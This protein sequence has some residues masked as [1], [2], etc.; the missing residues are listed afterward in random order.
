MTVSNSSCQFINYEAIK[1][2]PIGNEPLTLSKIK[3]SGGGDGQFAL[4]VSSQQSMSSPP[5]ISSVE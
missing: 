2:K 3:V 5:E 1:Q 4:G